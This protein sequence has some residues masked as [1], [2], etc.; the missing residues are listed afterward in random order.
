[1]ARPAPTPKVYKA[2]RHH[3]LL[4]NTLPGHLAAA[5]IEDS[6]STPSPQ[7]LCIHLRRG[8]AGWGGAGQWSS[9]APAAAARS[10]ER[11]S[12]Q[13]QHKNKSGATLSRPATAPSIEATLAADGSPRA[14]LLFAV[15]SDESARRP[16]PCRAAAGYAGPPTPSLCRDRRR[17]TAP[18]ARSAS[19]LSR[20]GSDILGRPLAYPL[21]ARPPGWRQ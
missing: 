21:A 20:G 19:W 14:A 17:G 11:A 9:T 5:Y 1:M 4:I 15:K 2:A 10:K 6:P 13:G 7:W 12:R 16:H 3:T 18:G 8:G